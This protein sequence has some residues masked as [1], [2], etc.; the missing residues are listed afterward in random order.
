L[1]PRPPEGDDR[2]G[3]NPM[4]INTAFPKGKALADWAKFINPT[5]QHG[6][7]AAKQVFDNF[8]S[9][10]APATQI[11]TSSLPLAGSGPPGPRIFSINA[12]V[13]VPAEQQCGRAVHMDAHIGPQF[14]AGVPVGY[15]L[16]FTQLC[17]GRLTKGEEALAFLFFDLAACVQEDSRP[18]APPIIVP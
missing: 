4:T 11:W 8:A 18:I 14:P 1:H 17:G 2:I 3:Q 7:L 9:V 10:A 6:E 13:G 5:S 12:P 16:T 15:P